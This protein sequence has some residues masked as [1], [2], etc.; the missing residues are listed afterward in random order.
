MIWVEAESPVL[1]VA[2]IVYMPGVV[3]L[4]IVTVSE[5]KPLRLVKVLPGVTSA[6]QS[7]ASG[8]E[9]GN[10]T[11]QVR[12]ANHDVVE[13]DHPVRVL[14]S[15]PS[16][17]WGTLTHREFGD[18]VGATQR[19]RHDAFAGGAQFVANATDPARPIGDDKPQF[20]P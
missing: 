1:P 13:G 10:G 12:G 15:G 9:C 11:A 8:F 6:A 5:H 19:P 20:A 2:T 18:A 16:R 14:R 3:F 17:P 4:G 7:D